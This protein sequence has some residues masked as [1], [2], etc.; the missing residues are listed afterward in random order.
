MNERIIIVGVPN[1][2]K[3]EMLKKLSDGLDKLHKEGAEGVVV[4]IDSLGAIE[5]KN[6]REQLEA[7]QAMVAVSAPQPTKT[8]TIRAEGFAA[9]LDASKYSFEPKQKR[10]DK[11][12]QNWPNPNKRQWER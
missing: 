3:A 2:S 12:K 11:T 8:L 10:R 4:V 5:E 9:S 1:E 6:K 7:M